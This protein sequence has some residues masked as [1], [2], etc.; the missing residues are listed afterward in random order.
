MKKKLLGLL[1]T[2][3]MCTTLFACGTEEVSDTAST[4][5]QAS[6]EMYTIGI[7]QFGDFGSLDNCR[8]G[9]LEGLSQEGFVEG[10]NLTV[11]YENAQTDTGTAGLISDGFVS[12]NVDMICAI[13]T[14]SAGSSFTATMD[15]DIPV[16]YTAVTDPI[17]SGF[18]NEDGSPAGNITGTNDKLP[19][20]EQLK[21]IREILPE[22][23]TIG[24]I[25]TTSESNSES[26]IAEYEALVGEYGFTLETIGIN[27]SADIPLAVDNLVTKVDCINNLT[28][29][30]VVQSLAIVLEKANAANIPVFGSEEEQVKAGC[31]ASVGIDYV[32][33]GI[34][35]GKMAAEILRGEASASEMNFEKVSDFGLYINDAAASNLNI[36]I[37]EDY[38]NTAVVRFDTIAE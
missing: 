30:T 20:E 10:E 23:K 35:T 15:T 5:D 29:N 12:Q 34:Q 21:M 14:P 22:A 31:V 27:T 8:T 32:Q 36:A 24:I 7:N 13:A 1:L 16:I 2:T 28:D 19:V 33:L 6:N 4:S 9:L 17:S 11:L 18:A 26:A 25:Y 38:A 3:M 37:D